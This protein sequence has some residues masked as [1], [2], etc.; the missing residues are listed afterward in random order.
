MTKLHDLTVLKEN[1]Q[2]IDV[3]TIG[4]HRRHV[5]SFKSVKKYFTEGKKDFVLP[6]NKMLATEART[7]R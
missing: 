1:S 5:D 2:H 6:K 4:Y 7:M 3:R